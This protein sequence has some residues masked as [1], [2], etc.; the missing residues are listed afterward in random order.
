M[1]R[2]RRRR[3]RGQAHMS[4]EHT[5]SGGTTGMEHVPSKSN[6]ITLG[7]GF[8]SL[9]TCAMSASV[10]VVVTVAV[11]DMPIDVAVAVRRSR[12]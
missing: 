9:K 3:R 5:I 1:V 11:D 8:V 4:E 7:N 12:L 6:T 10:S 2:S